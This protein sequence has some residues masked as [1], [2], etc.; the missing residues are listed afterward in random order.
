M[1]REAKFN[2]AEQS[3]IQVREKLVSVNCL[4]SCQVFW[5]V[6]VP[7]K[8]KQLKKYFTPITAC[9]EVFHD[10]GHLP[11]LIGADVGYLK[12]KS[13]V[14][15]EGVNQRRVGSECEIRQLNEGQIWKWKVKN[16]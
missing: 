5:N 11:V 10:R 13:D 7:K 1:W 2:K 4:F 14:Y 9:R 12:W 8:K 3:V 15:N 16:E 6:G